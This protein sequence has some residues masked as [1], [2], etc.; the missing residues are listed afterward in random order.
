MDPDTTVELNGLVLAGGPLVIEESPDTEARNLVLRH[1]TL[2]PGATRNADGTPKSVGRASLIV[3][4]PFASVTLDHCIVGPVVAVEGAEVS[5]NDSVI[6]ASA[7]D[8]VAYCGRA[9]GTGTVTSAA[10]RDTGDG[11]AAG[12]HLTLE[13]CTVLGQDPRGAPRRLELAAPRRARRRRRPAKAPVWA[14]RRQ[15][16]CI[17]FSFVPPGSRTPRRFQCA[18]ADP[19][20]RPNHTSLRYG[21]P[22]YMQLR[23]STHAGDPHGRERRERDGRRRTSST[24]RNASPTC[25]F[26]STSTSATAS[27]PGSSTPRDRPGREI[28]R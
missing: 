15:V 9:A 3:L 17:R 2:V 1:C 20:Q 5:A 23:R 16:G 26:A 10:D 18:G 28:D 8:E 4:H 6:D 22:G 19:A 11:L 25:G 27:R 7:E 13:S 21:D 12:G 24:R 14:E